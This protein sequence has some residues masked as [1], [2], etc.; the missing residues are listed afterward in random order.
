MISDERAKY[1]NLERQYEQA[2]LLE[3][4]VREGENKIIL[5]S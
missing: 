1:S 2:K 3:I 4:K 5:L